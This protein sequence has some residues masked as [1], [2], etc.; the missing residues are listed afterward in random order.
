MKPRSNKKQK[1]FGKKIEDKHLIRTLTGEGRYLMD[2]YSSVSGFLKDIE[3]H[4]HN[5]VCKFTNYYHSKDAI[6]DLDAEE[7]LRTTLIRRKNRKAP[8]KRFHSK[9][10]NKLERCW[11]KQGL[12]LLMKDIDSEYGYNSVH[13]RYKSIAWDVY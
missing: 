3:H 10:A 6:A 1:Y 4:H 7:W 9:K 11:S 8:N 2:Y 5:Y 13:Q 12:H